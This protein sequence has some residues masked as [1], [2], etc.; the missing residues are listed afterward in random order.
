MTIT[1]LACIVLGAVLYKLYVTTQ[2]YYKVKEEYDR[3]VA[4]R[5]K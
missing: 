2:K 1:N 3:Y 4:T 5:R